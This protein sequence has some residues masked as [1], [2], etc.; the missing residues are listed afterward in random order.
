M[1]VVANAGRRHRADELHTSRQLRRRRW[2]QQGLASSRAAQPA[3]S[4]IDQRWPTLLTPS[5]PFEKLLSSEADGGAL[6]AARAAPRV[7]TTPSADAA[8]TGVE[9]VVAHHRWRSF[10]AVIGQV[11]ASLV[12]HGLGRVA[13]VVIYDKAS[14]DKYRPP[15]SALTNE[16]NEGSWEGSWKDRLA[17]ER[18]P[19]PVS[20]D[21]SL[22]DGP[23]SGASGRGGDEGPCERATAL[24]TAPPVY[25]VRRV[26]NVGRES[27]TYL[28]HIVANYDV[29]LASYTLCAQSRIEHVTEGRP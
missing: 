5:T 23:S 9:V 16:V 18:R 21:A 28:R 10:E 12:A 1:L 26:P 15:S 11:H 14:G 2:R 29:G 13:R 24:L 27:E 17:D 4:T 22:S 3:Q 19:H 7:P 8:A 25:S 6:A 20:G